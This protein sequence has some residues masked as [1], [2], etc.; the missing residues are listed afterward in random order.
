MDNNNTT[1]PRMLPDKYEQCRKEMGDCEKT[2]SLSK[3]R[4][5]RI[6]VV[7]SLSGQPCE[8][9]SKKMDTRLITLDDSFSKIY[10]KLDNS[11]KTRT[12]DLSA[13]MAYEKF[14][15]FVRP[16][17]MFVS[18]FLE[19]FEKLK[20]QV[21][22]YEIFLPE[23]VLAYRVLKS[24][25]LTEE[26]EKY[27]KT[28]VSEFTYTAVSVLLRKIM[29]SSRPQ[30][31]GKNNNASQNVPKNKKADIA[32]VSEKKEDKEISVSTIEVH[33]FVLS[34]RISNTD[35]FTGWPSSIVARRNIIFIAS[36]HFVLTVK[37]QN[38]LLS[39]RSNVVLFSLPLPFYKK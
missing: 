6:T 4:R 2:S 18:D 39:R 24:A 5:R 14:E 35:L 22:D 12:N 23:K 15:K 7:Q 33:V 25:N 10:T 19:E 29:K 28:R 26:R 31:K 30:A 21:E 37:G 11:F 13:L 20:K 34:S 27:V 8:A 3:G 36:S 9:I 17:G 32:V 38:F 1:S 16:H